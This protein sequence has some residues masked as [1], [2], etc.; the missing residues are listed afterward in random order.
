[1]T[2]AST[3]VQ[4]ALIAAQAATAKQATDTVVLDVGDVLSIVDY[5]VVTSASN[6]RQ[7]K[8]IAEEIE[9]QIRLA[10]GPGPIRTEGLADA[11]WV[12]L[13]YGDVVIHVFLQ[14]TR[15]FYDLERLWG[16]VAR[17]E[18]EDAAAKVD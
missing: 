8:T 12:L 4:R 6:T 3:S 7:V 11:T 17:L 18:W 13:D 16:D 2:E 5:F 10:G 15:E 9:D 1:V 14:E